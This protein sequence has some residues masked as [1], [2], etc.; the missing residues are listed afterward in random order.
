MENETAVRCIER[1]PELADFLANHAPEIRDLVFA[2]QELFQGICGPA[3]NFYFDA[4]NAVCAGI[5]YTHKSQDSFVN[6]ATYASHVTLIFS[7][8]VSLPDPD[9]RLNGEGVRVRN[10]RLKGREDLD[11]PTFDG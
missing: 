9:G 3:S 11:A 7:N 5:G 6:T 2:A 8:G 1:N 4:T 10:I